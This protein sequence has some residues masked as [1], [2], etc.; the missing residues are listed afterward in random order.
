MPVPITGRR[1]SP[2]NNCGIT[3]MERL[4]TRVQNARERDRRFYSSELG[5]AFSKYRDAL[6]RMTRLEQRE[7]STPYPTMRKADDDLHLAEEVF[8]KMLETYLP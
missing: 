4:R 2:G 7:D 3:E 1:S 8:R 5:K 6:I